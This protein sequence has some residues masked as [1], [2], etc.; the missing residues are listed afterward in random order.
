MKEV[1]LGRKGTRRALSLLLCLALCLVLMPLTVASMKAAKAEAADLPELQ[2]VRLSADGVLTCDAFNSTETSK[3]IYYF[4]ISRKAPSV[5]ATGGGHNSTT[6]I[7]IKDYIDSHGWGEGVYE[8]TLVA[9]TGYYSE[10]GREISQ[11]WKG[12]FIYYS[13]SDKELGIW[14]N[15]VQ[16]T[17]GNAKTGIRC[18]SG[19]ATLDMTTSPFTVVL[20]NAVINNVHEWQN[21]G[22]LYRGCI[23]GNSFEPSGL[24]DVNIKVIGNCT[25]NV[26]EKTGTSIYNGGIYFNGSANIFGGGSLTINMSGSDERALGIRVS[27][28]DIR[29]ITLK[30]DSPGYAV[31]W[32]SLSSYVSFNNAEVTLRGAKGI[33]DSPKVTFD[34]YAPQKILIADNLSGKD[35]RMWDGT[36]YQISRNPYLCAST[37]IAFDILGNPY[38]GN[39]ITAGASCSDDLMMDYFDELLVPYSGN[40]YGRWI[41]TSPTGVETVLTPSVDEEYDIELVLQSSWV[42]S[43]IRAEF[44]R[45]DGK[46]YESNPVTIIPNV[47]R[48]VTVNG[49]TYEILDTGVKGFVAMLAGPSDLSGRVE[50]P[51]DITVNGVT[52]P[53]TKIKES[54]FVGNRYVTAVIMPDSVT[55]IGSAIAFVGCTGLKELRLS[56]NLKQLHSQSLNGCSQLESVNIPTCWTEIPRGLFFGCVGLTEITVPG[57]ISKLPADFMSGCTGLMKVTL[58]KGVTEIG[59]NAFFKCSN[60]EAIN[61]PAGVTVIGESAFARCLNCHDWGDA[62]VDGKLELPDTLTAIGANAF[63]LCGALKQVTIPVGIR[64]IPDNVFYNCQNLLKIKLPES[65][66]DVG[67]NAFYNVAMNSRLSVEYAGSAEQWLSLISDAHCG[68]GNDKLKNSSPTFVPNTFYGVYVNGVQF[69]NINSVLGIACGNGKAYLDVSTKPYVITLDNATITNTFEN[70]KSFGG[71]YGNSNL[72]GSIASC[73]I[74]LIGE[75]VIDL[76]EIT[77]PPQGGAAYTNYGISFNGTVNISGPGSLTITV[78]NAEGSVY[79]IHSHHINLKDMNL[80]I[81]S[82]KYDIGFASAGADFTMENVDATL[83]GGKGI[84][85]KDYVLYKANSDTLLKTFKGY[86][87]SD[88]KLSTNAYGVGTVAWDGTLEVLQDAGY[89]RAPIVTSVEDSIGA[90]LEG[91]S[92]S[93]YDNIGVNFYMSL[94][95]AVLADKSAKFVINLPN[96]TEQEV[97]VSAATQAQVNGKTYYVFDC[98]VAAKEM[99]GVIRTQI[100]LGDG[101]EGIRYEFT[102]QEYAKYILDHASLYEREVPVVKAMLNYGAAAQKY[103]DFMTESPANAILS[104]ADKKEASVP[105]LTAY[106]FVSPAATDRTSFVGTSLL[107][108]SEV[109]IKCYFES[110]SALTLSNV[111]VK[112]NGTKV[113]SSRIGVGEDGGRWYILVNGITPKEYGAKFTFGALDLTVEDVSVYGYMS[114][115]FGLISANSELADVMKRLYTYGK[116]AAE[117]ER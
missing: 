50:I 73:D 94:S 64:E 77:L 112:C 37:A 69:D 72:A 62:T 18:G 24:P 68:V 115:A 108:E 89:L 55:D 103:F 11:K 34:G 116:A 28:L 7:N 4:S 98:R 32:G 39:T 58:E 88:I 106:D 23:F 16:F 40:Q 42:G 22:T 14:V 91:Y 99:T 56:N 2:N 57:N 36:V 38:V 17:T 5:G 100:V 113:D 85:P 19:V 83:S 20:N 63:E 86:T 105:N 13:S 10:A 46:R 104:E 6:T 44:K 117:Y 95:N 114:K 31:G 101:T 61:I 78:G 70:N 92:L 111:T 82:P 76:P 87:F 97:P 75:N 15:G 27:K 59:A 35:A 21:N 110:S 79:G 48:N 60:L 49:L 51:A 25:I 102:V 93:L 45:V 9:L 1:L 47:K 66:T 3:V 33:S 74:K 67:D 43:T 80:T 53:V 29:D 81:Y 26:P 52:I 109:S 65:L 8:V 71:I 96:G 84:F 41:L 107:L 12:S 90:K 30:V 54:L